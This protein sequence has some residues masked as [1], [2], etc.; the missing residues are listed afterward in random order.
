MSELVEASQL[1]PEVQARITLRTS[2]RQRFVEAY[3]LGNSAVQAA[4]NAGYV[5]RCLNRSAAKLLAVPEVAA[6]I[7]VGRKAIAEH[8]SF[9]HDKA[10]AQLREDRAFAI[11]TQNATAAVRASELMAKMSGHLVERQDVRLQQ[12]P[13]RIEINTGLA[14][15]PPIELAAEP[16][17]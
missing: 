5:G 6:A 15:L 10:M 7:E 14:V 11:R 9:T 4:K 1:P 2:R 16:V 12:V 3:L 13:L 8:A 17:K